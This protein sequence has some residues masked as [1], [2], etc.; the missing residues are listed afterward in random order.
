MR[1]TVLLY[2]IDGAVSEMDLV[3][4]QRGHA[5][6]DQRRRVLSAPSLVLGEVE[7]MDDGSIRKALPTRMA[8][9]AIGSGIRVLDANLAE[10]L[11]AAL[12]LANVSDLTVPVDQGA[13]GTWISAHRGRVVFTALVP[14]L[15]PIG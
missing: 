4:V 2:A 5:T 10:Q 8:L 6:T 9:R 11:G 14:D 15:V 7:H 1:S 12:R 13:V 3:A